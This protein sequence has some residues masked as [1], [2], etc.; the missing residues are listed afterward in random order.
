M[1]PS[2][3]GILAEAISMKV[4]TVPDYKYKLMRPSIDIL[5]L[6]EIFAACFG[7]EVCLKAFLMQKI[8]FQLQ[9]SYIMFCL[10]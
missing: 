1:L 9:L 3:S 8:W 7:H 10:V 5:N 4:K 6:P 2:R